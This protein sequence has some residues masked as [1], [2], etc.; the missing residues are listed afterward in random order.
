MYQSH[1]RVNNDFSFHPATDMTA[2]IHNST[3]QNF[4]NLAHWVI[5]N[6]PKG[7]ARNEC[8]NR[9]REAM[10][11]ANGAIACDSNPG[12]LVDLEQPK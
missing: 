6:V 8:V 7:E 12:A 2:E 5:D 10:M 9:L 4:A 3:R 11:W 1:E